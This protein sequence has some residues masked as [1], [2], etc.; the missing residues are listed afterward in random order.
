MKKTE[1]KSL[2]EYFADDYLK[3]AAKAAKFA[4]RRTGFENLDGAGKFKSDGQ[5]QVFTPGIYVIG[6]PPS[7]GKTTW[8]LQ[9]MNQLA[10][11]GEQCLFLSYEMAVQALCRKLISRNLFEK[12]QAG[13]PVTVL[14]S[15]DIRRAG[16]NNED[17]NAVVEEFADTMNHL[18]ILHVDWEASTLIKKLYDFAG[19]L[20]RPPVIAIDYLQMV[21]NSNAVTSKGKI[22]SLLA[23]LRK[24]QVDTDA[25]LILVSSFNRGNGM[26]V[27]ATFSSFKESG[28][29]EYTADVLLV[30]EPAIKNGESMSEAD[31]RER[32]KKIRAMRLRC[33]KS[34]EGGLYEVYFRYFA[35]Y[36][37]FEPC[38]RHELFE[39]TN[40]QPRYCK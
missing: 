25:T 32:Q 20:D 22:D 12:K 31:K 9:L 38:F 8:T 7:A 14:S 1:W 10:D 37:T 19:M 39:E 15:A 5:L 40:T 36:D 2:A 18:Q 28:A 23:L 33:L 29:I 17:I 4:E 26:Q 21:P 34:R 27:E 3:E 11:K 13:E 16:V 30:L 6:A 35:S 24:F